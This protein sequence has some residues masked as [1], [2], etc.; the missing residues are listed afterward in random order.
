MI[1]RLLRLGQGWSI[2]VF[3]LV[4]I[5]VSLFYGLGSDQGYL[6]RKL[7]ASKIIAAENELSKLTEV[8]DYL[9][10]KVSL[11][12]DDGIDRDM[13]GELGRRKS[14]LY[15]DNEIVILDDIVN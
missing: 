9:K 1:R 2:A 12:S 15:A 10:N 4:F 6:A 11:L 8:N 3:C 5:I 13:L 7:A 14:G